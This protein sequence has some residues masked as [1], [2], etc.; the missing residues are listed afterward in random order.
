MHSYEGY[1][2]SITLVPRWALAKVE[3]P[4]ISMSDNFPP[5]DYTGALDNME[6]NLKDPKR[7]AMMESDA[8]Y[9]VERQGGAEGLVIAGFPDKAL[10]GKTLGQ[11]AREKKL[12]VFETALWLARNGF[13]D[14]LGGVIWSM[15]AVGM[16]DIEEWMRHD[17]NGVSL[18]RG[19]DDLASCAPY[20]HPGTWGTSGRL[21]E[22]FVKQR[23]TITLPYAIRSLTSV[24]TQALGLRDRGLLREGMMADVVVFDLE[25]MGTDATYLEPCKAQRGV[26]W[27]VVNGKVTLENGALGSG[28]EG[29]L[30]DKNVRR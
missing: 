16:V 26:E 3:V 22:T 7:R 13:P 27:V 9:E 15:R 17:W 20:T 2:E 25:E 23:K 4:G 19:V 30:I 8:L 10:V 24:G 18:D 21:I 14:R 1:A 6:R 11:V 12:S 28:V 29:R 5:V